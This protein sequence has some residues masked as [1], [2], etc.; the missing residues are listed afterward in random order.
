MPIPS[1]SEMS[2][3]AKNL[4]DLLHSNQ[5]EDVILG[6]HLVDGQEM[7]GAFIS[8]LFILR[9]LHD[10]SEVRYMANDLFIDHASEEIRAFCIQDSPRMNSDPKI[11]A[12]LEDGIPA[13]KDYSLERAA[14]LAYAMKGYMGEICR[15]NGWLGFDFSG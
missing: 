1:P 2:V 3:A 12:W 5:V 14:R 7:A 15:K 4:L 10:S 11:S 8:E 13:A 6:L 9:R